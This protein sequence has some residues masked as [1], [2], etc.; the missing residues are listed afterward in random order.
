MT[1]P[2]ILLLDE[3]FAAVDADSRPGVRAVLKSLLAGSNAHT[4]VVSHDVADI[5]D[6]CGSNAVVNIG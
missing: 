1:N 5:S 2:R 6:L 3:P 4:V